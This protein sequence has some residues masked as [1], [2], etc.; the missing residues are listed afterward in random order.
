MQPVSLPAFVAVYLA[1]CSGYLDD[2]LAGSV[3][4]NSIKNVPVESG[5]SNPSNTVSVRPHTAT[6][7]SGISRK[8]DSGTP[9]L[10]CAVDGECGADE[11]CN[12]ARGLCVPCRK[13]RKRCVRDAMCCGGNRC[14]NGVCQPMEM[15][16]TLSDKPNVHVTP[17]PN[18]T[19]EALPKRTTAP[20]R[21]HQSLKGREGDTCL[22]SSDCS[23]GLCCARHFWSRI[24]KPV[25]TE[26]QVCTRH[27]RKGNHGLELF[28]RCDCGDGLV[29][30]SQK[31]GGGGGGENQPQQ[32]QQQQQQQQKPSSNRATRNLH[33]CQPR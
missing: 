1:L 29:C 5:V 14:S 7:D 20:F 10:S 17:R 32:Q 15:N 13:R 21:P 11:F 23:E 19:A 16:A 22:R 28:Q 24:C 4:R 9:P 12:D 26:G 25:L 33:T 27:R 30:R 3:L 31:G 8:G 18:Y 2:A 6:S